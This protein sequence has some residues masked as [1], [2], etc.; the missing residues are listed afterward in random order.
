MSQ[1]TSYHMDDD[2]WTRKRQESPPDLDKI[3]KDIFGGGKRGKS[4]KKSFFPFL[5]FIA[6]SLFLASGFFIVKPAEKAVVVR[7]GKVHRI[8]GPGPNWSFPFIEVRQVLDVQRIYSYNYNAEMLTSDESYADVDVTVFYRI[9]SPEDFL[10][11]AVNPVDALGQATA[12][13]L[14]QVVGNTTYESISTDGRA[15]ARDS[16]KVHIERVINDYALGLEITDTKLQDAKMPDAVK[17]AFDDVIQAREDFDR[18]QMVAEAYRNTVIP[19]ASG[20]RMRILNEA[21]AEY[22]K[23]IMNAHAEVASFLAVLPEY[24]RYPD[25]IRN[26]MFVSTMQ[27]VYGK[28]KKVFLSNEGSLNLLPLGKLLGQSDGEQYG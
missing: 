8:V 27:N 25:I 19:K 5:M 24:Q 14:R 12:S 1:V 21:N 23:L 4:K 26:K 10:F 11:N 9:A 2:P 3:L 6:V 20:Q 7:L 22:E 17:P 16:I 18:F 28:T 15:E 13:S